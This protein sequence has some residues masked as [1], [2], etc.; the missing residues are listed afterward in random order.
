VNDGQ[1]IKA[2]E[3]SMSATVDEHTH[4]DDVLFKIPATLLDHFIVGRIEARYQ[5]KNDYGSAWSLKSDVYIYRRSA[6]PQP[7]KPD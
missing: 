1:L 5:I 7:V 3:M 2:T 6:T 4:L